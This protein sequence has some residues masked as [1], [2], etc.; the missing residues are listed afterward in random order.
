MKRINDRRLHAWPKLYEGENSLQTKCNVLTPL[1]YSIVRYVLLLPLVI[2]FRGVFGFLIIDLILTLTGVWS[3]FLIVEIGR[4]S[5]YLSVF[6]AFLLWQLEMTS[7]NKIISLILGRRIKL[8]VI[9]NQIWI[10]GWFK[11]NRL[12]D[13]H[14]ATFSLHPFELTQEEVYKHSLRLVVNVGN[15]LRIPLAEIYGHDKAQRIVSNLNMMLLF[16][17]SAKWDLDIDPTRTAL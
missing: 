7:G 12:C 1:R 6:V 3:V 13:L 8:Q 10:I 9:D 16:G 5:V 14:E 11:K 15:T 17:Q 4:G 2:V